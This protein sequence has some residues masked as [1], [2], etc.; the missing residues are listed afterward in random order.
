MDLAVMQAVRL[1][2]MATPDVVAA[3]TGRSDADAAEALAALAA[4]GDVQERAGRF[5]VTREGRDRLDAELAQERQGV[6]AGTVKSLYEE[7]TPFNTRLK[8]I[9]HRWQ[10]RDGDQPNDHSDSAYDQ[11]VLSEL[12]A[13]DEDLKS[14]FSR[15]AGLVPRLAPYPGRFA[16]ALEKVKAGQHEW[17]LKPLADSYHTVWFELH[18]DLI[19]LAGLSRVQEAAEGRAE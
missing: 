3:A 5:R 15:I 19:G 6:D 11:G 7:F 12:Y 4:A 2:G 16:S 13:L 8:E 17:L 1:K 18:E 9:V 10:M 14:L